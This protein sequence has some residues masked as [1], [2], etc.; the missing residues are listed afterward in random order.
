MKGSYVVSVA[1]RIDLLGCIFD[2]VRSLG[3][4]AHWFF[5]LTG[6]QIYIPY[7]SYV[8]VGKQNSVVLLSCHFILIWE[9]GTKSINL[10]YL[11]VVVHCGA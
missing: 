8:F 9:M 4:G 10:I 7:P 3:A 2:S 6:Q 1:W 11:L 5:R